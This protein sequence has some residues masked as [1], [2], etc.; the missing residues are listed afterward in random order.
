MHN[1]KTLSVH[2]FV[3]G[4]MNKRVKRNQKKNMSNEKNVLIIL[5]MKK[6]ESWPSV[7]AAEFECVLFACC[8]F[9]TEV[10]LVDRFVMS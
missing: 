5:K 8:S 2:V 3:S 9:C 10:W 7:Y 6:Q 1:L 4:G